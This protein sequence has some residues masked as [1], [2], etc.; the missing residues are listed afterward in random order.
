[1]KLHSWT[2]CADAPS[3]RVADLRHQGLGTTAHDKNSLA[4]GRFINSVLD[5]L[6]DVGAAVVNRDTAQAV[7]GSV[8]LDGGRRRGG[9]IRLKAGLLGVG[10]GASVDSGGLLRNAVGGLE[11]LR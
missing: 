4:R 10:Y 1:M 8:L 6:G 3:S 9:G 2:R 7:Q 11:L 5:D